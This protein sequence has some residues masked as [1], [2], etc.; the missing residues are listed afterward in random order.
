MRRVGWG[1]PAGLQA[2]EIFTTVAQL[3]QTN[4]PGFDL[5]KLTVDSGLAATVVSA[6]QVRATT[7]YR[8]SF[9][10]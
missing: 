2:G 7:H 8:A 1:T 6:L 10:C 5:A 3:G 9:S 4:S